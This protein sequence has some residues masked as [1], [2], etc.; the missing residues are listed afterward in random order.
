[1]RPWIKRT[2]IGV[3]GATVLAGA[4]AACS[5]HHH[6]PWGHGSMS[7][8]DQ[9]Q[10]RERMVERVAGRLD[11]DSAQK[12]KLAQLA[13]TL[14]AQRKAMMG[15]TNPRTELE[16]MIAGERF[17]RARAQALL[18]AKTGALH[19]AAPPVLAAAADFYDSLRPDQQQKIRDLL[20]RGGHR[21]GWRG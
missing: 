16:A 18:E 14:A 11:L 15:S 2:L 19:E 17:D 6:G 20:S 3:F 7:E 4:F 5:H 13:D 9:A 10:W 1:M 12:A 8:A 21:H